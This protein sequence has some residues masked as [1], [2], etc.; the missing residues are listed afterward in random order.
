MIMTQK[1]LLII[2]GAVVLIGVVMW[3]WYGSSPVQPESP[4]QEGT[5]VSPTPLPNAHF[6]TND[7]LDQALNDLGAVSE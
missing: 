1:I 5:V 3:F 4:N 2:G 7:N 6:N